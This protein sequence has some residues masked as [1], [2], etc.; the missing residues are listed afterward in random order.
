NVHGV[1]GTTEEPFELVAWQNTTGV[2]QNVNLVIP[3]FTGVGG[4]D[5]GTPRVKLALLEN[6]H[7]RIA[8]TQY[9]TSS[10]GNIVGPDIFGHNGAANAM[11]IAAVPY[12]NSSTVE[13]YSSRGP[14]TLRFDPVNGTTPAP[15]ITPQTLNKPD[16]SAS[17][18]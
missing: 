3:R 6:G 5:T 14:V 9:T 18:C 8:P 13:P 4:G 17:D 7:T 12:N 15:P 1:G 10:G 16:V 2:T 11:S